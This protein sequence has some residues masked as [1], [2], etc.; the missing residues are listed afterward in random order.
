MTWTWR[1]SSGPVRDSASLNLVVTL[2]YSD[3]DNTY[4]ENFG[5]LDLTFDACA[6]QA[7][8]R[9]RNVLEPGDAALQALAQAAAGMAPT[10]ELPSDPPDQTALQSAIAALNDAVRAAQLKALND[11]DVDAALAAVA[12]AQADIKNAV[13]SSLAPAG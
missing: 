7:R 6:E 1:I 5:A 10:A 4:R 3:G 9:I 12:T 13:S 11:P 8:K 2:E